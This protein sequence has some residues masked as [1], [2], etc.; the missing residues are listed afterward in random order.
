MEKK[1]SELVRKKKDDVEALFK[2]PF[3]GAHTVTPTTDTALSKD[4]ATIEELSTKVRTLDVRNVNKRNK[5]AG[6]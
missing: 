2:E 5:N 1:R 4:K 3:C 6:Y